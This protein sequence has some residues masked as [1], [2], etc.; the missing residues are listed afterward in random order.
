MQTILEL[1]LLLQQILEYSLLIL[2]MLTLSVKPESDLTKKLSQTNVPI[3]A[4]AKMGKP[5]L[6]PQPVKG[7]SSV[8]HAKPKS[9]PGIAK[10]LLILHQDKPIEENVISSIRYSTHTVSIHA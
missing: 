1:V 8:I 3:I 9:R 7:S 10:D 6:E 5:Q 2:K 4:D